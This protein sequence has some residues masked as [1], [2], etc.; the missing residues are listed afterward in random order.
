MDLFLCMLRT[1]AVLVLPFAAILWV[2]GERWV[3][4]ALAAAMVLVV[5]ATTKLLNRPE[6]ALP[7]CVGPSNKGRP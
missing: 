2:D 5:V 1:T 6:P 7:I 4:V 3:A